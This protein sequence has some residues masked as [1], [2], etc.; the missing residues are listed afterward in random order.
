MAVGLA[1]FCIA[2]ALL[3]HEILLMR[4]LSIVQWHHFASMIISLALL[5]LGAA[6]TFNTLFQKWLLPRFHGVFGVN[7]VLFGLAIPLS[8]SVVQRIP[9]NPLEILWDPRQWLHLLQTY[10]VLFLPFFFA[11]NCLTL[12]I[13]RFKDEVHRIYFFDLLGAGLGALG[14]VALLFAFPPWECLAILSAPGIAAAGLVRLD[15]PHRR[16]RWAGLV[17]ILLGVVFPW[18]WPQGEAPPKISQYKGLSTALLAPGAEVVDRRTSPLG[19][20]TVVQSPSIPFRHAPGM[21]LLCASEPPPQLGVFV[22]GDSMSPITHVD[23]RPESLAFLECLTMALPFRLVQNPRVL[24]LGAGGGMDV[25]LAKLHG[26]RAIEAVEMDPQMISLAK[27]TFGEYAGHLYSAKN[28]RVH[29]A[30]ARSFMSR[31]AA[32]YDVIQI[33]LL[34]SFTASATGGHALS[35][36]YLYTVEALRDAYGRLAPGGILSITRWLKIPPRDSLKLFATAVL[37]LERAGVSNPG[38]RLALI[39][40]WSTTTLLIKN[41]DLTAAELERTR[42]F[43]GERA[44]DIDHLPGVLDGEG[45]RFNVLDEPY[46]SD[47][48]RALLG[49]ERRAFTERYKF[50]IEPAT[51][52]RPYFFH[53]FRW[54][55]LPEILASRGRGGLPLMEWGYPVLVMTLVQALVLSLILILVPLLFL[56]RGGGDGMGGGRIALYFSAVGFA[57]LFMEIAFIQK[58]IL[59]LGNPITAVSVVIAGFLVFAG[60]GSRCSTAVSKAV[61]HF[62]PVEPQP[63]SILAAAAGIAILSTLYVFLLPELFTWLANL[64]DAGRVAVSMVLVAPLAFLMGMPFP[65]GLAILGASRPAHVPWAWGINGCASVLATVLASIVAIHFGFRVVVV[66]AVAFYGLAAMALARPR[67]R[68]PVG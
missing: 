57:F 34:D 59:F 44:F 35:E 46:L 32:Y 29:A 23:G 62:R 42:A 30:E 48:A 24:V 39:R 6:G 45:N 49:G 7:A 47:G 60:I 50:A 21:S 54:R 12:A 58:L 9:L 51:D 27:D 15:L 19:W 37:A 5:G 14:I 33:S 13:A 28:V 10:L 43:C 38:D 25:L 65:L 40:S 52:D 36:S 8:F 2:M 64:G 68:A 31:S 20:L 17:L 53:F 61:S 22:D 55:T 56:D 16:S 3:G 18:L 4:L 1:V 66:L 26:A 11:G 67:G 41:G 63:A